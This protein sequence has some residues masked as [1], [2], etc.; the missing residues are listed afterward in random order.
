MRTAPLLGLAAVVCLTACG[1]DAP[2]TTTADRDADPLAIVAG[3]YPLAFATQWVGGDRVAV[4]NLTAAGVE[5]HD[6]E[7]TARDTAA[8]A[9]ADLVVLLGGFSPALDDAAESVAGDHVFDVAPAARLDDHDHADDHDDHDHAGGDPHF[10]LDPTRLADV[11]EALAA[12]LGALAPDDAAT[13]TA[14]A[15]ALG[16]ALTALDAEY[17][18]TLAECTSRDLV[19][20]HTAFGYLA[21][22]YGFEQVGIAGVS[23]DQEPSPA[24]MTAVTDF[25]R[26]HGVT[27]IYTETLV[28]PAIADTIAAETGAATA[29]LDPLEGLTEASAGD[30]Y[31]A[32]MR[33]NLAT[34]AAGQGCR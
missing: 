14:N 19:T 6:L 9:D 29:V 33:A 12:R 18:T 7:L 13:F 1:G 8:V 22:R 5:P 20:S 31:L 17:T 30:D 27:T 3:F 10:W 15:A 32:V 34:L 24:A 28:D 2:D 23:P 25:V 11:A 21:D 26:E 4:T 16:E